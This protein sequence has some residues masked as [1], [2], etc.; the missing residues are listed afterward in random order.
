MIRIFLGMLLSVFLFSSALG[1]EPIE[2]RLSYERTFGDKIAKLVIY[3]ISRQ[4]SGKSDNPLVIVGDWNFSIRLQPITPVPARQLIENQLRSS[5][6]QGG[7]DLWELFLNSGF[8]LYLVDVQSWDMD[9]VPVG[10]LLNDALNDIWSNRTTQ[11]NK[12]KIIGLGMGGVVARL[13]IAISE[14]AGNDRVAIYVSLDSPHRGLIIPVGIQ[15]VLAFWQRVSFSAGDTLNELAWEG[16]R[17]RMLEAI[18]NYGRDPA[19]PTKFGDPVFL[20]PPSLFSSFQGAYDQFMPKKP[21]TVAFSNG[22][23][24]VQPQLS[25]PYDRVMFDFNFD[26]GGIFYPGAYRAYI[27]SFKQTAEETAHH[28]DQ[29]FGT[30]SPGENEFVFDKISTPSCSFSPPEWIGCILESSSQGIGIQWLSN[31]EAAAG[32][33]LDSY[34]QLASEFDRRF[35]DY[36][37]LFTLPPAPPAFTAFQA[38]PGGHSFVPVASALDLPVDTASRENV[39][40]VPVD[41]L[42]VCIPRPFGSGCIDITIPALS[43]TFQATYNASGN[44]QHLDLSAYAIALETEVIEANRNRSE[45][46]GADTI[47]FHPIESTYTTSAATPSCPGGVF[48]FS[49][50]LFNR[51]TSPAFS[52]LRVEATTLKEN[53]LVQY[54]DGALGRENA[55]VPVPRT[56]EYV[57]GV[58][59]PKEVVVVPFQICLFQRQAF[60]FF[61]NVFGVKR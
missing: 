44:T 45:S 57:D 49:A 52:D 9:L 46:I 58:L 36:D 22:S 24:L 55:I 35:S 38:N 60:S 59:G 61:V 1:A 27:K 17:E 19:D 47:E 32:G 2:N 28:V 53:N 30:F 8:D 18:D 54:D 21:R 56:E 5:A 15:A 51:I 16:I 34:Q 40:A 31:I 42:T 48:S 25:N 26:P 11:A 43:S 20:A 37:P 39:W 12:F 41:E 3:E 29:T 6:R 13:A 50:Q 14:N 4:S 7:K 33:Y 10:V 23:R